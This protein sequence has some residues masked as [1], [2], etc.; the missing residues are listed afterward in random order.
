MIDERVNVLDY[1]LNEI[2]EHH[3]IFKFAGHYKGAFGTPNDAV[4]QS[5]LMSMPDFPTL[6]HL[7]EFMVETKPD[8]T[9]Y[10]T[11]GVPE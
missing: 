7:M 4:L 11:L 3:T 6:A 10:E 2:D 8:F 5:T 9:D 1:L